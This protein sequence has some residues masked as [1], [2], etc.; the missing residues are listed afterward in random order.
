MFD[1]QRFLETYEEV[2]AACK[3]AG[4]REGVEPTLEQ[5]NEVCAD[6]GLVDREKLREIVK[7]IKLTK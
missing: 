5:L 4:L 7:Q 2:M 6:L 1:S 3:K